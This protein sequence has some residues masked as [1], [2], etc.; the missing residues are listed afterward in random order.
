MI[1]SGFK[2]RDA[3][4][5]WRFAAFGFRFTATFASQGVM[6]RL[7]RFSALMDNDAF[8]TIDSRR[9]YFGRTLLGAHQEGP[10]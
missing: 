7:T 1:R 3:G 2:S 5:S 9:T 8:S 10:A 4:N 6:N